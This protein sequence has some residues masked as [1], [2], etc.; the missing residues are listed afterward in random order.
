[1]S[2]SSRS[3][4]EDRQQRRC[5][6][7]DS[8]GSARQRRCLSREGHGSTRQRRCLSRDSRGSARQRR[9]LSCEGRG[10]ARQ[11]RCPSREGRGSARQ[12]H[13]LSCEGRGSARQRH[14]LRREGPWKHKAKAVSKSLSRAL[15]FTWVI[16]W[17]LVCWK[18][19]RA[20][21]SF[22]RVERTCA[23]TRETD[24]QPPMMVTLPAAP[25]GKALPSENRAVET[26]TNGSTLQ[27]CSGKTM[28][29]QCLSREGSGKTMPTKGS[30]LAAKTVE[31]Q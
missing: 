31:R 15:W 24:A 22:Q 10:S 2:G 11:R 19:S 9:C 6:S 23:P 18:A 7:R 3:Q 30:A 20:G 4:P 12:R 5:L 28:Q 8:R 27:G 14:C 17:T 16:M 29:R 13:C 25:Q 1:M 21:P 26:Q